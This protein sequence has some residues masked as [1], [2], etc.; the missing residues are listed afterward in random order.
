MFTVGQHHPNT[1]HGLS[2]CIR[3]TPIRSTVMYAVLTMCQALG[4]TI[5]QGT[6]N[7]AVNK[8]Q[9][10]ASGMAVI[11][12]VATGMRAREQGVLVEKGCGLTME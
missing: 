7:T 5:C 4:T 10:P 1:A 2:Y 11:T 8:T 6:S 9:F 3:S 12:T